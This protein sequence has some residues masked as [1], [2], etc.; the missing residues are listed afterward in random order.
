MADRLNDP[1][2]AGS[3]SA[4]AAWAVLG[5]LAYG[6]GRLLI[7]VIL[8]KTFLQGQVGWFLVALAIVTPLSFLLNMELRLVL[9]TDAKGL[10]SPGH[11]LSVRLISNAVFICLMAVFCTYMYSRW[12][13]QKAIIVFLAALVR[14]AE[15]V[16]EI[17]LAVLQKHERMKNVA[18]SQAAKTFLVLLW[19][20][21]VSRFSGQIGWVLVGWLAAVVLVGWLYD[22]RRAS[23]HEPVGPVWPGRLFWQLARLGMPLGVFVT[24]SSFHEQVSRYFID[25]YIGDEAVAYYAVMIFVIA[26]AAAVQNGINQSVLPRL[27]KYYSEGSGRFGSLLVR[28]L[29]GSLLVVVVV[30]G[31]LLW[32]GRVLLRILSRSEYVDYLYSADYTYLGVPIFA[33]VLLAGV[34]LLAGMIAGDAIIATRRF[35]VRLIAVSVGLLVHIAICRYFMGRYG[36]W[37]AAWG[38]LVSCSL[39]AIICGCVLFYNRPSGKAK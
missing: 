39:A 31:V 13:S 37:A 9:V 3:L 27:A 4:N 24:V 14:A 12:P 23:R 21:A 8:A 10:V 15:S 7:F 34:F 38:Q 18:I 28:L 6:V 32:Q 25:Y 36:L 29:F 26:G 33:I 30:F 22:S 17:Y 5:N 19:V 2:R 1:G 35:K 11:C 20:L 16:T